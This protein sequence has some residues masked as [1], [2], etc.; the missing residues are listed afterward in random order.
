MVAGDHGPATVGRII[1]PPI[2]IA[3]A[4]A[5][6]GRPT[7]P[8]APRQLKPFDLGQ[9][10]IGQRV[11][12]ELAFRGKTDRGVVIDEFNALD[13]QLLGRHFLR[14]LFRQRCREP[15]VI[16]RR[17]AL[18][19]GAIDGDKLA[20]ALCQVVAI[21]K[22][23]TLGEPLRTH[24]RLK[25]L[26]LRQLAQLVGPLVVGLRSLPQR[27]RNGDR[28]TQPATTVSDDPFQA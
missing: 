12:P 18:A 20:P 5:A 10:A 15:G 6:A 9:R 16:E 23:S 19:G 24:L 13:R 25:D 1:R 22:P 21:P 7:A 11:L 27:Q 26:A 17:C 2:T 14:E 4:P 28:Q 3:P 8:L